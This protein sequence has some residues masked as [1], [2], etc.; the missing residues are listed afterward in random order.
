[1]EVA[2]SARIASTIVA[3]SPISSLVRAFSGRVCGVAGRVRSP[4]AT[5]SRPSRSA[6][7]SWSRSD[8]SAPVMSRT[9]RRTRPEMRSE[10]ARPTGRIE[11]GAARS[12]GASE[13]SASRSLPVAA[14]RARKAGVC[15]ALTGPICATSSWKVVFCRERSLTRS[16]TCRAAVVGV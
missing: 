15:L 3:M 7:V 5:A 2:V 1:M 6:A 16:W 4:W 12:F 8:F 9:L 11:S 14:S 13:A 10:T